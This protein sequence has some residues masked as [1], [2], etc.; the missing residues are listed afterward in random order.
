MY[1][2]SQKKT[3]HDIFVYSARF[4]V[5]VYNARFL[6]Y[7]YNFLETEM[8]TLRL[9]RIYYLIDWWRDTSNI[10]KVETFVTPLYGY[11]LLFPMVHKL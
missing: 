6:V 10:R 2:V 3:W 8:N 11:W 9:L 4:L 7:V 5:Y 1:S